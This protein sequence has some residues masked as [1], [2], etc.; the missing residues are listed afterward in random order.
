MAYVHVYTGN[1]KGK[2]TAAFGVAIRSLY[3]NKKVYVGQF[4]KSMKYHEVALENDFDNITIKQFG[5]TCFI[6]KDPT[7]KDIQMGKD[8]LEEV[9]KIIQSDKYDLVILDEIT[10]GLYYKLFSVIDVIDILK[11]RPE[12]TE[13]II[14]GRYAPQE[15]ID[16]ADLVTEM[17]EVKHY[18]KQGVMS[19][20]GIDR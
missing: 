2:T 6:E 1:G 19:R 14:T 5:D 8:G 16:Y 15:L 11:A 10:I 18:Y 13:I 12:N 4:I 17:K 20:D 9:N 7:E 3:A